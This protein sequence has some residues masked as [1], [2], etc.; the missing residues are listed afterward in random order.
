MGVYSLAGAKAL[1]RHERNT[2]GMLDDWVEVAGSAGQGFSIPVPAAFRALI[3]CSHPKS[4][5]SEIDMA[6]ARHVEH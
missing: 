4:G 3:F 2:A 1:C 5:L 6:H